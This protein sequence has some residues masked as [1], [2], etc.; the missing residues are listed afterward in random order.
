[1]ARKECWGDR[2]GSEIFSHTDYRPEK[3]DLQFGNGNDPDPSAQSTIDIIKTEKDYHKDYA[4]A[5]NLGFAPGCLTHI[6]QDFAK[7]AQQNHNLWIQ[8]F[9]LYRSGE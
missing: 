7:A 9:A 6:R 3:F 2:L 4:A 5:Q 8:A 1:M